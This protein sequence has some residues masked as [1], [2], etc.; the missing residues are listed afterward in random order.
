MVI[1]DIASDVSDTLTGNVSFGAS[2]DS[3]NNLITLSA[4]NTTGKGLTMNWVQR[5]WTA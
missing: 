3:G 2:F 5:R 4:V 1:Q